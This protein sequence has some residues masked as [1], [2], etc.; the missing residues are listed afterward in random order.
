MKKS[1]GSQ[2]YIVTGQKF[3]QAQVDQLGAG[4]KNKQMQSVFNRLAMEHRDSIIA[5]QRSGDRA[6]LQAR[7]HTGNATGIHHDRRRASS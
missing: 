4:L 7:T 1:S 3:S 5:I 2:F 6:G